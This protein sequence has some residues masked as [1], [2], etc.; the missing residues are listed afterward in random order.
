MMNT[1]QL[2]VAACVLAI[3]GVSH[4]GLVN[5]YT[6]N[7]GTADDSTGSA[8]GTLQGTASVSGGSL[9]LTGG[10]PGNS[11]VDLGAG[12]ASAAGAGGVA[13]AVTMEAWVTMDVLQGWAVIAS[14]GNSGPGAMD[15]DG[16]DGTYWQLIPQNGAGNNEIR[17]TTHTG[18]PGAETFADGGLLMTGVEYHIVNTVDINTGFNTLYIDGVQ[19]GQSGI[20]AG[21]DPNTYDQDLNTGGVQVGDTQNWLGR[22]QWGDASLTGSINEFNVYDHA[23]SAQ[24]VAANFANGPVPEPGSL[25]L[26]GLGGLAVLR[27]RRG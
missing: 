20:Q 14:F 19:V 11:Y 1:K 25:A 26:L 24:E 8:D 12:L 23:L 10:G 27:R 2:V 7:D 6:F 22:S 4:A 3:A 5:S 13:G 17:T 21:F 15:N 18:N 16:G 9:I